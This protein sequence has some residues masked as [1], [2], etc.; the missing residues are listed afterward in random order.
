MNNILEMLKDSAL[1]YPDSTAFVD[2]DRK[3]TFK[4]LYDN[5]RRTA[6]FFLDFLSNRIESAAFYMEK[7]VSAIVA[8]FGT[9]YAGGFYSFVDVRQPA[10]RAVKVFNTLMPSMIITDSKNREGLNRVLEG[11]PG[12]SD[13]PVFDIDALMEM[14]GNAKADERLLSVIE[15]EHFDL[16]PL[17]V[18]FTSGSTGTPKGVAVSHRSVIDFITE[19]TSVFK[20]G[21]DDIL[22]NQAPFDFDVSVKDIYSGLY[23]GAAV[24]LIPRPYFKDP[25]TLMDYLYDN[26]VTTLIWAVSAMCFVSIMNGLEYKTP[27]SIKKIM[28]SGEIMPVKQL[29]KWKKYLPDAMYVNLY[30][31]TEITC[32]C[33]YHILDREYEKDEIIP[34][35]IPFRN[36]KVFLLDE[37]DRLI[38]DTDT[39][40]EICVSGTCLALGY[41]RDP[42]R[43]DASFMQNPS[44]PYPERM[45]RTGDLGKYDDNGILIYTTRKDFQIKHMGQR[46]E[47]GEIEAAAMSLDGVERACCLYDH[48]KKRITLVY[49]GSEEKEAVT[50]KLH[51]KLPPYM[52]PGKTVG[53]M[54]LP[55]N[56]NGKIDR[57]ALEEVCL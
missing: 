26:G 53:P 28:F 52:I 27:S 38:T 33:T 23:T 35:G 6:A 51:Q 30:G 13:I 11:T 46:I 19:F 15:K 16:K 22:A 8:M 29:N 20:I 25:T 48:K 10:D 4:E 18:N 43:T 42:D 17:Y 44:V 49:S 3:I 36:E 56:K 37:N 1:N 21:H 9:V 31:P 45:Y 57:K 7:S 39:E 34:I 50:V 2:P 47:L 55:L 41:Y 40:G 12:L 5:S 14:L 32:N 24:V 54:D